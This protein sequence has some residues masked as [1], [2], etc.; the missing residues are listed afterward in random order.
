MLCEDELKHTLTI[1]LI[2]ARK[3][4]KLEWFC[5]SLLRQTMPPDDVTAIVVDFYAKERNRVHLPAWLNIVEP[6]PSVWYGP[7]RLTKRDWWG[8]SSFRNTGLCLAQSEWFAVVDDRSL[9]GPQWLE[10]VN[11]A[12]IGGY[13]VAGTYEKTHDMNVE[14][15]ILKSYTEPV[16]DFGNKTGKDPRASGKLQ[17]K[18]VPGNWMLG[19]TSALPVEWALEV[20]G[21]PE[22]ANG[23]GLEDCIF[24]EFLAKRGK[25]IKYDERMKLWE[26]RTPGQCEMD[27]VRSDYGISP[28]DKSHA[29]VARNKNRN[30]SQHP[31]DI[32]SVR[33]LVQSG[34]PFPI[35]T[36]P[37]HDW[38]ENVPLKELEPK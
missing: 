37:T 38:W 4:P 30:C 25:P 27:V 33:N 12:M 26:D 18:K 7:H 5:E 23:V 9:L 24:G 17:P 20:N 15:G 13:A 3:E 8:V 2:T 31:F 14:N 35:E 29:L 6:K 28:R 16:D 10:A 32:R 19:C 11:D 1:C 34:Q 22:D 21:W 36:E